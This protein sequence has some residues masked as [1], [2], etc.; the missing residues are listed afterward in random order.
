MT[1]HDLLIPARFRGPESSGNGG[2]T[3]GAL[4]AMVRSSPTD[5]AASWPTVEVTLRLP[6][7]LETPLPVTSDGDTTTATTPDGR[8]VAV[9][10]AVDAELTPVAPVDHDRAQAAEATYGGFRVHP[11]PNC[12]T[13]GPGRAEGDG[14]RIFPGRITPETVAA[15]WTPHPSVA[16]DYHAYADDHPR[17]S[18]EVTWAALDCSGGWSGDLEGRPSVLGRMTAHVFSL[19]LIG[20]PHVVVGEQR[21]LDGR[22][23]FTGST[24]Y[25]SA[26][27]EVARAEH[28]WIAVD[29]STFQ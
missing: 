29:P 8:A 17:A 22:K 16:E 25:D 28:V 1:T 19:P 10:R 4:A 3:S 21:G 6:P 20:E 5:H 9:A 18:V 24:L 14:L 27:R 26:G 2:W 23:L 13:C 7:P 12:F 15:T 11:F